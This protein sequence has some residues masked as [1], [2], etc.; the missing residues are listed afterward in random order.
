MYNREWVKFIF[1]DLFLVEID[2]MV[3]KFGFFKYIKCFWFWVFIKNRKRE[4]MYNVKLLLNIFLI[5]LNNK[6]K[7][8]FNKFFIW[9]M[10]YELNGIF[11]L[12][13][14]KI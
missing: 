7:E 4:F 1:D 9:R 12:R 5:Y 2:E 10:I 6:N 13:K 3:Y 11:I 8:E 14:N